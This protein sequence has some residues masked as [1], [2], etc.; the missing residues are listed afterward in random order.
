MSEEKY[1]C[2]CCGKREF[3]TFDYVCPECHWEQDYYQEQNP[4]ESGL[5]NSASLNTA[6]KWYK[7]Y[8]TD[9]FKKFNDSFAPPKMTPEEEKFWEIHRPYKCPK[10]GHFIMKKGEACGTCG[11]VD[12]P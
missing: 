10:C 11:H 12:K 1:V 2:A 3:D 8:G 7:K 6:K 5:T 4:D 9:W